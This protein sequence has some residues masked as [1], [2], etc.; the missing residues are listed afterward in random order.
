M[1]PSSRGG[2]ER[3]STRV[4]TVTSPVSVGEPIS[5]HIEHDNSGFAPAWFLDH[6][7]VHMAETTTFF[8]CGLWL[9]LDVG[10]GKIARVLHPVLERPTTAQGGWSATAAL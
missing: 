7:A 6:V 5:L 2:F 9:A 3:G 10:D 4:F 1:L 8:P